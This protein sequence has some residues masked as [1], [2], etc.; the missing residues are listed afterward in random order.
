[1]ADRRTRFSTHI[2]SLEISLIFIHYLQLL[3]SE[4]GEDVNVQNL[5][6]TSGT[7]R[8]RAQQILVL[9][10]KVNYYRRSFSLALWYSELKAKC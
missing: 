1:M 2:C 7:W 3:A 5:L 6:A 10:G 8:G 4:V 9:Q